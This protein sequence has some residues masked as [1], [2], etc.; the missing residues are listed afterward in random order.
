MTNWCGKRNCL[1]IQWKRIISKMVSYISPFFS[2]RISFMRFHFMW[3][4]WI[5]FGWEKNYLNYVY[6]MDISFIHRNKKKNRNIF[7]FAL[8]LLK[9]FM[10]FMHNKFSLSFVNL[11]LFAFVVR[12]FFLRKCSLL[13]FYSLET[14]TERIEWNKTKKRK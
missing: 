6:W 3:Y 13:R 8:L 5:V 1:M 11:F 2:F 14:C 12:F 7:F 10:S 4:G 9:V